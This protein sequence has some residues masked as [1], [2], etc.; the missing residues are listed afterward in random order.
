MQGFLFV[1]MWKSN[2]SSL[3]VYSVRII[4]IWTE[5]PSP[6]PTLLNGPRKIGCEQKSRTIFQRQEVCVFVPWCDIQSKAIRCSRVELPEHVNYRLHKNVPNWFLWACIWFICHGILVC[7]T[8]FAAK[9]PTA[10]RASC[11]RPAHVIVFVNWL[12]DDETELAKIHKR[13]N[14]R[15]SENQKP[16]NLFV[17]LPIEACRF[18]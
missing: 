5:S 2:K 12:R 18:C 17:W 14:H 6:K 15:S 16:D 11:M 4:H 7:H 13:K 1:W 8:I 9:K 10:E 3:F